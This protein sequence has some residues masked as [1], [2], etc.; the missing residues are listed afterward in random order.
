MSAQVV[1]NFAASI[2]NNKDMNILDT[3]KAYDTT[4]RLSDNFGEVEGVCFENKHYAKSWDSIRVP[5]TDLTKKVVSWE[6]YIQVTAPV[7]VSDFSKP[8]IAYIWA[9]EDSPVY[10][11]RIK[12]HKTTDDEGKTKYRF[13]GPLVFTFDSSLI[14][15]E[16]IYYLTQIGAWKKLLQSRDYS[17]VFEDC[18]TFE[19]NFFR[20]VDYNG[21]PLYKGSDIPSLDRQ[22][23]IIA[24]FKD[25]EAAKSKA[26]AEAKE[27]QRMI[28]SIG[29]QNFRK[30][31]NFPNMPL[32]KINVFVGGNNAGKSTVVKAILTTFYNLSQNFGYRGRATLFGATNSQFFFDVPNTHIG[33]FGR[34]LYNKAKEQRI[35]FHFEIGDLMFAM[36]IENPET[37][38]SEELSGSYRKYSI[39]YNCRE[40]GV[41][42]P[43]TLECEETS[44]INKDGDSVIRLKFPMS[45]TQT[46]ESDELKSIRRKI[47]ELRH[48][49]EDDIPTEEYINL[50]QRIDTLIANYRVLSD[51]EEADL[52]SIASDETTEENAVSTETKVVEIR[53]RRFIG[54]V[55][56]NIFCDLALN[57]YDTY[58]SYYNDMRKETEDEIQLKSLEE[59]YNYISEIL[60]LIKGINDKV[61]EVFFGHGSVNYIPAHTASQEPIF[62]P[63]TDEYQYDVIHNYFKSRLSKDPVIEWMKKFNIGKDFVITPIKGGAY[64]FQVVT[65]EDDTVEL[66]D[67]GMGAIQLMMLLLKLETI[68]SGIGYKIVLVEEPEQNLHPDFQVYLADIFEQYQRQ[69]GIQ[70]I[71]ETHSEYL[72]RHIQVLYAQGKKK[73]KDYI[74]PFKVYYFPGGLA[75]PYDMGFQPNGKFVNAFGE[76]FDNV[77][78]DEAI[79]LYDIEE[80][81]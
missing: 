10:I 28:H 4:M 14:T 24:K 54:F 27:H 68:S 55:G 15:P 51:N 42:F 47:N 22:E 30:F 48:R 62:N 11:P 35:S 1:Y 69:K 12:Q 25:D 64:T 75:V 37:D 26:N 46:G 40:E 8:R 17:A 57:F 59:E 65:L 56:K 66:A 9:S 20:N 23:I 60:P 78:Y 71:I 13:T 73:S 70:F 5:Q 80:Q 31:E 44:L 32:G 7:I 6:D 33:T 38:L 79:R 16:F 19:D 74:N 29:F 81:S 53:N 76:G 58:L 61:Q 72:V 49:L 36:D 50:N 45:I 2:E 3:L 41:V 67:L 18:G 77:A 34:A 21:K 43:I 52:D 63:K 39:T